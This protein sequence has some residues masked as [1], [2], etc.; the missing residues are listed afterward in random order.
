MKKNIFVPFLVL[1]FAA[2]RIY[3]SVLG[4]HGCPSL[5]IFLVI[6]GL[7]W[8][9]L[10]NVIKQTKK[11]ACSQKNYLARMLQ[12]SL[13]ASWSDLKLMAR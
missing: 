2:H 6:L 10:S 3:F 12:V 1:V 7:T 4:D 9:N 13:I 5:I 11:E 8:K